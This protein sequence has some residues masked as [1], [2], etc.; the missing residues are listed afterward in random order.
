MSEQTIE[1]SPYYKVGVQKKK[2]V[3]DSV[4]NSANY[5]NSLLPSSNHKRRETQERI[6]I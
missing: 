6:H 1:A 2:L 3:F 4:T 5:R